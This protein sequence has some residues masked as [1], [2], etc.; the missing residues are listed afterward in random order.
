M[1]W[2]VFAILFWV[3]VGLA[4]V[5]YAAYLSGR[6]FFVERYPDEIHFAVTHDGWRIAAY[7]YRP[8]DGGG[9]GGEPVLLVHGPATNRLLFDLTDELSLARRLAAAGHDTWIAELRGRGL[10][11]RPRLFSRFRYDWSFDEYVDQDLP[12]AVTTV[13]RASG[14]ERLH[15]VGHS[16]GGMAIYALLG[17][18]AQRR[19]VRS[20]VTLG[21]PATFRFQ[22]KYLF[23][24]PLRNL[25]W[26]RHRFL[27]RLIAPLSGYRWLPSAQLLYEPDHISGE[28]LRR[29]MVNVSANFGRN[30]LLQYGDWIGGDHFRSI[31]HR[32]DYREEMRKIDVPILFLAGNKDRLAPPPSVKDACELVASSRKRFLIAS[33][34]RDFEA[35]YGHLDL[36]L[37]ASAPRDIFPVIEAWLEENRQ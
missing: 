5:V 19:R 31:D 14:R 34:G 7:R 1:A 30:E 26:L 16:L 20:V 17:D 23:S 21:A 11:T 29:F 6:W 10:A 2:T 18:D 15:L 35:N 8:A 9:R 25:R 36:V 4:L 3:I 13:L 32:R 24:W 28:V 12:A 22:G 27:L 33:R 37:G